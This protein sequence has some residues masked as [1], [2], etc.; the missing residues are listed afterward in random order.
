ME[1]LQLDT[2]L[3]FYVVFITVKR[4]LFFHCWS[5]AFNATASSSSRAHFCPRLIHPYI[6]EDLTTM[7]P[8]TPESVAVHPLVL[9][10]VVDHYNRVCKDTNKYVPHFLYIEVKFATEKEYR[11]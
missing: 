11:F 5:L 1:I 6:S 2:C 10:S 4:F 9:L 8:T 3:I 7:A